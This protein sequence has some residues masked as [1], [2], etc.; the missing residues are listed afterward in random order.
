MKKFAGFLLAM[1]MMLAMTVAASAE[2]TIINNVSDHTFE[3]Y[4]IFSGT[5]T[6]TTNDISLGNI[7]WGSGINGDGFLNTLKS[8]AVI[9]SNFTDCSTAADVAEVLGN[10]KDIANAFAKIAFKSITGNGITITAGESRLEAGYYLIVDTT[11]VNGKDDAKNLALLDVTGNNVTI[12]NKKDTPK[13]EKKVKDVNDSTNENSDWQDSA[14]YDIGDEISYQLTATLP[15]NVSDYESYS[16][17][18]VDT[19]SKGLTY[20]EGSAIVK[21]GDTEVGTL[22]P[23]SAIYNGDEPKYT[24]GTVLTWN[25]SDVKAAPYNAGNEAV[26]TIEYTATL[27]ESAVIGSA[28]NPNMMHIV[29]SNNPNGEGTGKTPDDTNIVFTYKVVVNK[30][31]EKNEPLEGAAFTLYKKINDATDTDDGYVKL[32]E[33][34]NDTTFEFTG[35]DDGD[36]KLEETTT[37][38]GYNTIAPIKFTIAADH[39]ISDDNP[40]LMSLN[41]NAA[42]GEV[43]FTSDP[44]AGSLT[45]DVVNQKGATL[46]ETGGIGTT[47]FYVLGTILVLGAGILLITKKRMGADK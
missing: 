19:M 7:K 12:S 11:D 39:K 25:L 46:P 3:A 9:G 23:T 31:D 36:Y 18:F 28:G 20:K 8:D 6:G 27:N 14:D 21:V 17:S 22:V 4:Q 41:G 44:A 38:A 5:Q 13:S 2:D 43:T 26:I 29:Y 32:K 35:L 10:N 24:G 37:P 1:I 16:L 42:S 15:E 30:V 40:A 45:T 34:G 33:I 47:I